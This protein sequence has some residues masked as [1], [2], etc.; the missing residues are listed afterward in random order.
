MR[1]VENTEILP[2]LLQPVAF[3]EHI[4]VTLPPFHPR[5]FPM[6]VLPVDSTLG[7]PISLL[8]QR[9]RLRCA[10]LHRPLP[11]VAGPQS[12]SL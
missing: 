5:I 4:F 2:R 6:K 10:A 1:T 9:S 7:T 12:D 3:H 11:L 8:A